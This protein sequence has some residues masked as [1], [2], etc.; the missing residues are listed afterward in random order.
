MSKFGARE[1]VVRAAMQKYC[2]AGDGSFP[3]LR[4]REKHGGGSLAEIDR[5]VCAISFLSI[6]HA[7]MVATRLSRAA[8]QAERNGLLHPHLR[9]RN[10][11]A[12]AFE[13]LH[14]A[15][16]PQPLDAPGFEDERYAQRL[17]YEVYL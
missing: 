7:G 9:G 11:Y 13:V 3:A 14:T 17:E 16:T 12:V 6:A 4:T 15:G 2:P 5:P 8:T 1:Q 10:S